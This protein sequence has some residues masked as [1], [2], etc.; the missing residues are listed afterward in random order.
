MT[1]ISTTPPALVCAVGGTF[2]QWDPSSDGEPPTPL[3]PIYVGR[4]AGSKNLLASALSPPF[5][6]SEIDFRGQ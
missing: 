5:A 1:E 4:D 3:I 6:G 2:L